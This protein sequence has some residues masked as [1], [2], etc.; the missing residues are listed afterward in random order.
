MIEKVVS[1]GKT[2]ADRAGLDAA[3]AC[4]MP[5]DYNLTETVIR[6]GFPVRSY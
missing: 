5:H 6:M 1:G 2:G 3:I 4:G